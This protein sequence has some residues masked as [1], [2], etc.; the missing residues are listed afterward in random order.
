MNHD[1]VLHSLFIVEIRKVEF[2]LVIE[3]LIKS[4]RNFGIH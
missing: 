2:C 3:K 4:I 1:E